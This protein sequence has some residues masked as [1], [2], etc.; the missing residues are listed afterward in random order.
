MSDVVRQ[1]PWSPNDNNTRSL[2]AF[3]PF[4]PSKWGT[5]RA[6]RLDFMVE[7]C[8]IRGS[9][10]ILSGDG[11]LG[12]SLLCQQLMTAAALGQRWLGMRTA[13]ARSLGVFCEDDYEELHRRQ[14]MINEHYACR[15]QDLDAIKV[16]SL[17]GRDCTMMSFGRW[18]AEGKKTTRFTQIEQAAI[19]HKA[20]LVF[21]DTLADVFQGNEIDRNQ[22]RTFIRALRQLAI[23]IQGCIILTQ[24]PS[25]EGMKEGSGRSGSTGWNNSARSRL[26]LTKPSKDESGNKR[27]LRTMKM[28][29]GKSGGKISLVWSHGVFE[30]EDDSPPPAY[31]NRE[32]DDE[33]IPF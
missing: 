14:E 16:E 6:P 27:I 5:T 18:G 7:N 9:V 28:N 25:V 31:Y 11:G 15:M 29:Q 23:R 20:E 30:V 32:I 12:K 10:A 19:A 1:G 3:Q 26:Y 21:L 33:P 24:H 2:D 17:A 4:S 13:R 8:F 22:P